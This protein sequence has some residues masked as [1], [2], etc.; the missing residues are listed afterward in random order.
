MSLLTYIFGN[1][2][3]RRRLGDT[4]RLGY[5]HRGAVFG[6]GVPDDAALKGLHLLGQGAALYGQRQGRAA[7]LLAGQDANVHNGVLGADHQPLHHVLQLPHVARPGALLQIGKKPRAQRQ[8]LVILLAEPGQKPV[9][10]GQDV[11]RP[12]PQRRDVQPDH[13]QPVEEVGA[14]QPAVYLLLQIA[15]GGH[16]Q[17]DIQLDASGAGHPLDGLFLNQLQQLGLNVGRQLTDLI[18]KQCAAVGQLDLADLTGAGRA[19]KSALFIAEQLRFDEVFVKHRAVDLDEG[20]VRAVAHGVDG[21]GH[22]AFAHAGLAGDED[23][24]PCVG[25]VLHQRP[26]PLHRPALPHQTGGGVAGTQLGDLLGVLGQGILHLLEVPVDG[27]DLL[28]G[29]GVEAHRVLQVALSVKQRDAHGHHIGVGVVD[30]LGGGDLLL[31]ADDLRRDAGGKGTVRLQIKGRLAHDG[32]VGE[33][34]VLFICLADLQYG[35]VGVGQHHVVRQHQVVLRAENFKQVVQVD[36]L[37]KQPGD[38]GFCHKTPSFSI[39]I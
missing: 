29:H 14:E 27:V 22:G 5:R 32:A 34:K 20:L 15:V 11:L 1:L 30:G 28:H 35:A 26:Q 36:V 24:G 21:L 25:G 4:Q 17:P 8:I 9:G 23:I 38:T 12:L 7:H 39:H 6:V 3:C 2:P 37:R 18:Q 33:A 13:V 19:G 16:D 10:Q 31:G